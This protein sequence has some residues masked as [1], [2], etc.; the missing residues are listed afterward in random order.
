MIKME[1]IEIGQI[2]DCELKFTVIVAKYSDKGE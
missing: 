2:K 1:I